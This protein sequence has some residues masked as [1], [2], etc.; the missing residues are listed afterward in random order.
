MY[1]KKKG[2]APEG[3]GHGTGCPGQRAWPQVLEFKE[4][5]DTAL[6]QRVW[7]RGGAVWGQELDLMILLGPSQ[8]GM[9]CD[10]NNNYT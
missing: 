2:S 5:L 10:S 7:I 1:Y 6:R 9:F 8:L 4:H 3:G